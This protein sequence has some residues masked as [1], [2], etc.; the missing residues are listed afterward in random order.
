[1]ALYLSDHDR[2]PLTI[3]VKDSQAI[4]VVDDDGRT[5]LPDDDIMYYHK[6]ELAI[7]GLFSYVYQTIWKKPPSIRVNL[8]QRNTFARVYLTQ[9]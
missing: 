4:S 8:W 3:E 2:M 9:H 5:V 1:M 6:N 7:P